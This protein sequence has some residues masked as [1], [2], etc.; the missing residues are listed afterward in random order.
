MSGSSS[1]TP[2]DPPFPLLT[3]PDLVLQ[4]ILQ[5][6]TPKERKATRS[7]CRRLCKVASDSVRYFH[8][9]GA[10]REEAYQDYLD[11]HQK[12]PNVQVCLCAC[13]RVSAPA[14][15]QRSCRTQPGH[16]AR[17]DMRAT[18][19]AKQHP[20]LLGTDRARALSCVLFFCRLCRLQM[21]WWHQTC[22]LLPWSPSA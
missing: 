16:Q 1:I 20:A 12:F 3:L 22:P 18:A 6:L 21:S 13:R 9:G 19:A 15:M 7:T 5:H 4:H 11:L 2:G 8:V 14:C 10:I 17:T